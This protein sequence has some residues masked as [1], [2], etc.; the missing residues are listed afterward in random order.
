MPKV[1]LTRPRLRSSS[2]DELHQILFG[3]GV[4]IDEL[5]M[6]HF[7]LPADTSDL[8]IALERAAIGKFDLI[9]LSSP[10]AVNFFEERTR[11]LGLFDTLKSVGNFGAVGGATANEL[12]KLGIEM[13][14]PIPMHGSSYELS[15][16]L[17]KENLAGKSVLIL[18]SQIGLETIENALLVQGA[19]PERLTLYNTTGPTLGDSARLV[20]LLE[21]DEQPDVITFFS[22]SSIIYFVRTLAEM[23]AGMLRKLPA[24]ACI[25]ETTANAVEET[26]HRRPE[27]IARKANQASLARDILA[28]L[29]IERAF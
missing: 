10:T 20:R 21:S 25:G 11:E 28:Y 1:L 23:S 9:I 29:R 3:A 27:I 7:D 16:I 18:Q 15:L 22:P 19:L 6:I 13:A 26:L 4:V 8:D 2:D 24:L 5:P 12:A 14:L 17:A